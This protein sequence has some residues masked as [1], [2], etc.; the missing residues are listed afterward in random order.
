MRYGQ[1]VKERQ[2][3][4]L[5]AVSK[6]VIFGVAELLP[7][8]QISTSLL[9]RLNGTLRQH[10]APLHRKTRSFA[11]CRTALNTQTQFFK[12]YYN[13]CRK[14]GSLKGQTPAQA[15]KLTDHCWTLRELLTYNA[16]V[17]SK[18]P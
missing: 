13:L 5:V 15:A 18:I 1:V 2:G 7:L 9:E 14:H 10:V 8:Q 6:R 17:I 4:R 12:S 16:A 3:R 11:K